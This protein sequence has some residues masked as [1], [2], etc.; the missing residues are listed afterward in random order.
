MMT[1]VMVD[2]GWPWWVSTLIAS[3]VAIVA[4][5]VVLA[6]RRGLVRGIAGVLAVEGVAMAIAAPFLM[7]SGESASAMTAASSA[8]S[9]MG[10]SPATGSMG[11]GM[12]SMGDMG[13]QTAKRL[14]FTFFLTRYEF[15]GDPDKPSGVRYHS[16]G[17]PIAKAADGS[18]LTLL[19]SGAWDPASR[20]AVGGGIYTINRAGKIVAQGGWQAKRFVS[21]S[22][23]PGWWGIAG[24]KESGWQ[25]PQGS[26]TFSGV[27][28]LQVRLDGR[29][30]G[31]LRAWC[32]MSPE[33][34]RMARRSSDGVTL[35][36]PRLKF[37]N[38]KLN[39]G[40]VQGGV[41]FYGPGSA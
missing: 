5:A 37:T 2:V 22:Q 36:G 32:V 26:A 39:V 35:T 1:A 24:F 31:V 10:G 16:D 27:L 30:V 25:G 7:P 20:R 38:W 12:G 14:P 33:A 40:R 23:L 18:L 6:A 8:G 11:G 19:G 41:M 34:V 4:A 13:G 17:T 9:R 29:G 28:E 15:L 3:A 21:F